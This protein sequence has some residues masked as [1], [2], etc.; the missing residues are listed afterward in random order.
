MAISGSGK[1]VKIQLG[2]LNFGKDNTTY[3]SI[4]AYQRTYSSTVYSGV[5]ID[6]LRYLGFSNLSELAIGNVAGYT[7]SFKIY[8]DLICPYDLIIWDPTN[9]LSRISAPYVTARFEKGFCV[10]IS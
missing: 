6:T 1:W 8:T 9:D 7:G 10:G 4:Y 5:K 3:G 2:V